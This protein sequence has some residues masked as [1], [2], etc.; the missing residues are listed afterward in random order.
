MKEND[1]DLDLKYEANL[2]KTK[3]TETKKAVETARDKQKKANPE[4]AAKRAKEIEEKK[5]AQRKAKEEAEKLPE[6]VE[7][8]VLKDLKDALNTADE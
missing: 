4:K 7:V 5:I 3:W 6:D 8:M 2:A 1:D